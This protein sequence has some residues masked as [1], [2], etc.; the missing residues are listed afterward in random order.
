[1]PFVFMPNL[2]NIIRVIITQISKTV[3]FLASGKNSSSRVVD[4]FS[5]MFEPY[6]SRI[7]VAIL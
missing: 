7:A 1:M 4:V 6:Q 2:L 5:A 3:N